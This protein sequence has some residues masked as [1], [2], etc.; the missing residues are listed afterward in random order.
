MHFREIDSIDRKNEMYL[1]EF[2]GDGNNQ[3]D[4]L[5]RWK[6]NSPYFSILSKMVKDMLI[7]S[8]STMASS[9]IESMDLDAF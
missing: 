1:N 8:I 7:T 5:V 2:V 9:S 3:F 6:L 4:N